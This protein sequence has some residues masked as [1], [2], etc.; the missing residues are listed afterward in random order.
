MITTIVLTFILA[1]ILQNNLLS[2]VD[3]GSNSLRFH[4]DRRLD[5]LPERKPRIH[6]GW[7][8]K[9]DR[10][11]YAQVNLKLK[12]EVHQC[13]G[14]LVAP[15]MVMTAAHCVGSFD[16][17]EIGKY[18]KNDITDESEIFE[19]FF[20]ILH[21]DYDEET[22]RHDVMLIK[23]DG[24]SKLA[25]PV[26]INSDET[27]PSNGSMLTVIGMGYNANWDLPNVFQETS[28]QYQINEQ[29]EE[30]VDE[31]NGVTLKGDLYPD[32]LCAGYDERDSCYGDSGSP[33][34]LKG[35][36]EQSDIQIGVVR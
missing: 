11:S 13:G 36:D 1:E 14:R 18:Q 12:D 20:E 3:A 31:D 21:P 30:L 24:S 19:S 5:T 7:D 29:C 8:S 28:V 2:F 17:I 27:I 10:Y 35:D 33:L 34:V 26:R 15:D 4:G 22:T 32:M 16:K 9:E 23:L 6:G 25:T